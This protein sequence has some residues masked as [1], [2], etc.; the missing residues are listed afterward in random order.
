MT[1]KQIAFT[2]C[3][4]AFIT[5]SAYAGGPTIITNVKVIYADANCFGVDSLRITGY[6]L[7]HGDAQPNVYLGKNTQLTVCSSR[8]KL[9]VALCPGPSRLTNPG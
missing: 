5:T 4:V 8:R 1:S 2:L 6:N 7:K 3:L 9:L